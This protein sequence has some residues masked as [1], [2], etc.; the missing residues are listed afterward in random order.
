M[1]QFAAAPQRSASRPQ[2][3]PRRGRRQR[4]DL[5][6]SPARSTFECNFTF[7]FF[8]ALCAR[9]ILIPEGRPRTLLSAPLRVPRRP[10]PSQAPLHFSSVPPLV[11]DDR[12]NTA[13]KPHGAGR[14][15]G[16]RLSRSWCGSARGPRRAEG[17]DQ[18]PLYGLFRQHLS[19]ST[20]CH[21]AP[22][23]GAARCPR[24]LTQRARKGGG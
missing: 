3:V 15:V 8:R 13:K 2:A 10:H 20:P 18:E 22:R 12:P 7:Y 5:H 6:D 1:D 17:G 4:S 11:I 9:N 24:H 19:T 23:H 21:P 14:G 16:V